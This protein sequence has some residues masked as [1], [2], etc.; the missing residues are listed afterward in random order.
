MQPEWEEY[1]RAQQQRRSERLPKRQSLI[2]KIG[3]IKEFSVRKITDYQF[4]ITHARSE[5][6]ID[7]YPIHLRWHIIN[8]N[9]RGQVFGEKKLINFIK[10]VVGLSNKKE[11]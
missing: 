1:R 2:E 10:S 3:A 9:E 8:T 4:R 11:D 5:K 7:I 6:V